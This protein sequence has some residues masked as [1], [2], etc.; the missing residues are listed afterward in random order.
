MSERV[1]AVRK[2][3]ITRCSLQQRRA[4]P[5]SCCEQLLGFRY[6]N[7]V[8]ALLVEHSAASEQLRIVS[9]QSTRASIVSYRVRSLMYR[10]RL[11]ARRVGRV[12]CTSHLLHVACVAR[13][14]CCTSRVSHV[15]CVARRVCRTSRVWHVGS[16]VVDV[17]QIRRGDL[18]TMQCRRARSTC[19]SRGSVGA[20]AT[21]NP[22][23]VDKGR[24]DD[25]DV[26]CATDG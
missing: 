17:M 23:R 7:D 12:Y 14:V 21:T 8:H 9:F 13:R 16:R 5:T 15:A 22:R 19:G 1:L 11:F 24:H 18:Y 6:A 10:R 2:F 26:P 4:S 3:S 25:M 20:D